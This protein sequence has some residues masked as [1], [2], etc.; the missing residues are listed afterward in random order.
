M[1]K[2]VKKV[3][4]IFLALVIIS[5]S[6]VAVP[7][8]ALASE[9]A[10]TVENSYIDI[11]ADP[12][13]VLSQNAITNFNSGNKLA[14]LGGIKPYKRSSSSGS[15]SI[16]G[17][18]SAANYYL[19]LPSNADLSALKFW[20]DGTASI[21]GKE[22]ISGEPTDALAE[23]NEGGVAKKYTFTLG[24]TSYDVTA[25]KSGEV[26]TVYIDTQSGSLSAINGSS[27]KSVS[28]S[29]SIMVVNPD[30]TV[31]YN[32]VMDK[33]SGRG[34]GTWSSDLKK[35]YNVKLNKSTSLLGMAAAKKWCLLANA[36]DNS[37]I[38]DE[39]TYDFADYIGIKYQPHSKPVDLFVNGQYIGAYNLA[40]KVEIKSNRLNIA[41][42]NE[43]LKI[44]NGTVD[45]NTGATIPSDFS[46]VTV[47]TAN[48]PTVSKH[49]GHTVGA[50]RY[51]NLKDPS[52]YTGG[53]LYELEISNRWVTENAGFCAYNR[54]G[55]V[56][57][58]CDYASQ[59]MVQYSYD[60][61]YALGSSVY[62]GGIVP[63]NS[64]TTNCSSLSNLT[65]LA[66][67]SKSITNPAPA[68]RYQGKKWSDL[69]DADSAV[70]YYWTQEF[71]KNM[72]SSV[73][74]TYFYKDS[75]SVDS[76]LYAGPMWDMDNSLGADRSGERWGKSWTSS[77]GWFTKNSRIY[78][79]R[80][81]DSSTSYSKDTESPLSFY[82]ALASNCSDFWKMA[83]KSWY[84][85]ITPAVNV[86]LGKTVDKTGKLLSI[87]EYV[88][89]IAKSGYMNNIRYDINSSKYDADNY[90]T[91]FNNWVSERQTWINS[92]ISKTDLSGANLSVINNQ[93]YTGGE[94][95][96]EPS[97]EL[98]VTGQGSNVLEKGVDYTLSYENNVN[99]GTAQVTITGIGI[100]SGSVTKTFKI[101]PAEIN[102]TYTVSINENAYKN[103]ELKSTVTNNLTGKELFSSVTYQWNKNGAPIDGAT[104]LTY[105]TTEADAGSTITLTVTGDG[106]NAIG[107][108]TSNECTVLEGEKPET[109]T[110]SIA[111]WDYDFTANEAGLVGDT[112]NSY[113]ATS[114]LNQSTSKLYA[115]VNAK[116][117][118]KIKWSGTAD[119][120]KNDSTTLA[121]DQSPIMGTSKA[122]ALAW[123][124]YPYFE[125]VISTAGY[126]NIKFSAK[127][128]TTKKGPSNWKLQYSLDG[129]EYTDIANT[130]YAITANKT[131]QQA[132][133]NVT[134][135][136]KC[137]NQKTVYIR[138]V[139]SKNIAFNGINTI[140]GQVSGDASVNN[141]KITGNSLSVS[142][143]LYE[144]TVTTTDNGIVFNDNQV[145]ITDNN[146]GADVYYTINDGEPT[147]Y[148]GAFY[149]FNSKSAK[150]GDTAT[151][152]SWSSFNDIKSETVTKTVTFGGTNINSFVY[153]GF[154]QDVLLGSVASSG[155]IYGQS[156]KMSA[157][158][159]EYS[160]YVPLWND[161]NKSFTVA[162]DDG[163]KWSEN[164][165]F[166][167]KISTAGFDNI[168]FTCKAY[169]TNQGPNSITLQYS[170]NG[171]TYYN[172][173][174]N[175]VLPANGAL[176][177]VFLNTVLPEA[178]SNQKVVYI[179]LATTE[180]LTHMGEK[181]HSN[182]S[183]GNLY[184]NDV[185]IAGDD[186]GSYKMPYT[187]KS[188]SYFGTK[189]VIEY[190]SPDNAQMNYAV[191]DKDG[192]VVL[193]GAYP[194]G[195]IK[196]YEA[197]GFDKTVR[198]PYNVAVWVE[199]DE[200]TSLVNSQ[201]FYYKGDTVTE[202]N[203]NS[204][205]RPIASY[206]DANSTTLKNT[207][208]TNEGILMM[209]PSGNLGFPATLSYTGS[210]GVK[211]SYLDTNKFN[212][213]K[214]LNNPGKNGFW[215]FGI[216]TKGY[217]NL[218]LSLEQLSSNKGPRDW[219][220]AYSTDAMAFHYIDNSNV[221]T[222]SNDSSDGTVKT[223]SNFVLPEI[224]NDQK[225]LYI[226]VFIN[227]G[228]TVDGTELDDVTLTKGNTGVNKFE[229]TGTPV[230]VD[231]TVNT[232]VLENKDM[233]SGS[234]SYS[235]V[236]V[237]VDG[238][239]KATSDSNGLATVSLAQNSTH[240][241]TFKGNG[242][243]ERS[244]SVTAGTSD[245]KLN[246]PIVVFDADNN[247]IVNAKDF[248]VVNKEEKYA[249]SKQYFKNFINVE[250][251]SFEYK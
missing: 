56:L 230:T 52:D 27:D 99:V 13:G 192:N 106:T 87:N 234:I 136:D 3:F 139:V 138:M 71:F 161:K 160:Q 214:S 146:G 152:K 172:V 177:E 170:L 241:L 115:S 219:G 145:T 140:V 157:C 154:S 89:K 72:D 97:V 227:G 84:T 150:L 190:V 159:D 34:N 123:G 222:V 134:L 246:V 80:C 243:I 207:G 104:E 185:I 127:L 202:F 100:Y 167:Y 215:L 19:F 17:G 142:T 5:T 14:S 82:G 46:G 26:G 195:G 133:D 50:Y 141:I 110:K 218:T 201:T 88:D 83:E 156:G 231:Y 237:Y 91:I 1:K 113:L 94:L 198:E 238:I 129:T 137:N 212:A 38:K 35:P 37:L 199:E 180:N 191:M 144:P 51:S 57:K 63:R 203:Y 224:C 245:S 148:S 208:G 15:S 220:L 22:I 96:P 66:Y 244:V 239:K 128:G 9:D 69:L 164:S 75:D 62:N 49:T 12:Q 86:L 118:A 232:T 45:S 6:L 158:A 98:F 193:S 163:A 30:G 143:S 182:A 120:Y 249:K 186:N 28:E 85:T 36:M 132:F 40:E 233:T 43:N 147:L 181:L 250:A 42:V 20:F 114:G 25:L 16:I 174:S 130:D 61:L 11:W 166:T 111:A 53:Y 41:D 189:G 47:N 209:C 29:G 39:L 251:S 2:S 124:E 105:V 95:K 81:D 4:A 54:Q 135:P 10:V 211:V 7:S 60:L 184:V 44:A 197:Q 240:T 117:S 200:D 228:E 78:R 64:T 173:K 223:Y 210:Y 68:A 165:G 176:E 103:T 187:N 179:R 18:G 109:M 126:E 107:S 24:S 216:S 108:V 21:N 178:C 48:A 171:E 175:V 112:D 70:I 55:W 8:I 23:I 213:T 58:N 248:A 73:S 119:L 79:W 102:S 67:G 204:T 33:M 247:G 131:M 77:D 125:T 101:I 225:T 92:Q 194:Q 205:T 65:I 93:I 162:P 169:T 116:D 31:D 183:K 229:I 122:D 221:R 196:I 168:N 59:N 149:A 74:S 242:V 151:I 32:G 155:G 226:K 235:N 188:T 90:K 121:S 236:D 76:K 206:I 217:K 153:D